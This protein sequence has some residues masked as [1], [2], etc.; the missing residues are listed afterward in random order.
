MTLVPMQ[1]TLKIYQKTSDDYN[2]IS[3]NAFMAFAEYGSHFY[4][5]QK[6]KDAF[7]KDLFDIRHD[8][9]KNN[10]Y[11]RN[12]INKVYSENRPIKDFIIRKKNKAPYGATFCN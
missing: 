8:A 6:A 7:E 4:T 10:T 11:I 9:L 5:D 1:T 3:V 12:E 2:N